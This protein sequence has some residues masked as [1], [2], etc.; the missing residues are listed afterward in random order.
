V[1]ISDIHLGARA[2][3][4]DLLLEFLRNLNCESL[5]LV[6]D[7]VDGWKL[8]G[9][10]RWPRSHNAVVHELLAKAKAGARV[11]YIPGNHDDRLREFL[12]LNVAGVEV[13]LEAVHV[14][15]DGRRWL[16]THGDAFDDHTGGLSAWV[17][18][19]GYRILLRLDG[20]VSRS[21][22]G[23]KRE[24]WSF[25]AWLKDRLP[26]VRAHIDRFER[27]LAEAA[28]RRGLDGVVCGHIHKAELREI[29]GVTYVNDGDWVESCTAAI[30]HFD[31][32][33][34][35]VGW[36]GARAPA[37]AVPEGELQ[38]AAA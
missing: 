1:F 19:W 38:P 31:G 16:V 35:I 22:L 21:R 4:A 37:R 36:A 2:C 3:R 20:M 12:G 27:A 8:K 18:D 14:G 30:E 17:G 33:F 6:G 5:Y 7:V 15:A 9:G 23:L 24:N 28:R 13:A 25:A 32:R 10:W 34:E 29:D 26:P 11:V